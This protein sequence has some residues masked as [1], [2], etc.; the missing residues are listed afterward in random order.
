[1]GE[2]WIKE[3]WSNAGGTRRFRIFVSK[4]DHT[5]CRS[6]I[7]AEADRILSTNHLDGINPAAVPKLVEAC[8][9]LNDVESWNQEDSLGNAGDWAKGLHCGLEDRDI[10]DRYDAC[11]YGFDAGVE[12]AL[13]FVQCALA[14][15]LALA[16]TPPDAETKEVSDGRRG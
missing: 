9:A 4:N 14:E 11:D 13:E 10:H 5:V 8:K 12:R 2:K 6:V 3:V 1:M 15:A 16:E 7:E